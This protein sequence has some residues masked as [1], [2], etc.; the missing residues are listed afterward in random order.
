METARQSSSFLGLIPRPADDTHPLPRVGVVSQD[1]QVMQVVDGQA[2]DDLFGLVTRSAGDIDG[3]GLHDILTTAAS[4]DDVADATEVVVRV[5]SG[6]TGAMMYEWS[7]EARFDSFGAVAAPAGDINGDGFDDV[8]IG[9][10]AG[11]EDGAGY[12][13]LRSGA[14]GALLRR[15]AGDRPAAGFGSGAA[16][17]GDLDGDAIAD[18]AISAPGGDAAEERGLVHVVSGQTGETI[19]TFRA[20][21]KPLRAFGASISAADD[22]DGDGAVELLVSE[23]LAMVGLDHSG[24]VN[25]RGRVHIYNPATGEPLQSMHGPEGVYFGVVVQGTSRDNDFDGRGDVVIGSVDLDDPADFMAIR[26]TTISGATGAVIADFSLGSLSDTGLTSLR[27]DV[28]RDGVVDSAD[29]S[30]VMSNY[31][32]SA[33]SMQRSRSDVGSDG[34]VDESDLGHVLTQLGQTSSVEPEPRFLG[35]GCGICAGAGAIATGIGAAI[36]LGGCLG[37]Y[38]GLL[39]P[40]WCDACFGNLGRAVLLLSIPIG[41]CCVLF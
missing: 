39:A 4:L 8:I 33:P 10:P 32:A 37:Q 36:C 29:L 13:H 1:M 9:A 38:V 40:P 28:N 20:P 35:P 7:G 24:E 30:R 22:L 18:Y 16:G 25:R 12:V 21:H 11:G 34:A 19:R 2:D 14:D 26:M 3:D 17:L 23:P 27:A 41:A 15:H 31:G 5:Y 6:Q